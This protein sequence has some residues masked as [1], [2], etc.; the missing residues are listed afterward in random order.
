MAMY[1]RMWAVAAAVLCA[2][3]S[4]AGAAEELRLATTTS[5]EN[6]G[7]LKVL[8]PVF[9]ARHGI[10]VHVIA[11]GTGKALKLGENGDVDVVLVHSRPSE[12]KFVA[13]GFGVD[14]RDVMY[15]DFVLVGPPADPA[16]IRGMTDIAGAL[17]KLSNTQ[18]ATF[19]SRGD[20]SGT[21]KKELELWVA[22][23]IKP[24]SRPGGF[25]Y[26]SAGQGM[27]AVLTMAG[28]L[29]A[30]TLTDRGTYAAYHSHTALDILVSGVPVLFNPYGIIAVNPKRYPGSNY[31]GAMKLI[32]WIT[33]QEGQ[34]TIAAF[35]VN[36]KQLFF[37]GVPAP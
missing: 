15:N 12:D 2:W 21:H 35:K 30:Y 23:G 25:R 16:G 28:S 8:L 20:D 4:G 22:A 29:Q 19:V 31:A 33:S 11:V 7:L 6:S 27:G 1:L 26:L 24:E 9:E 32:D 18:Q 10:K 34:Q 36:G 37:P 13:A 5:T 14:R 3:A 17:A